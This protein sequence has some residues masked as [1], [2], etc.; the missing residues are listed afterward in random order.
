MSVGI[1]ICLS[2]LLTK[3]GTF[4]GKDKIQAGSTVRRCSDHD[5]FDK[6]VP[7]KLFKARFSDIL[8]KSKVVLYEGRAKV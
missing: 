6:S 5:L 1:V 3:V 2:P 4:R 8:T 7:S